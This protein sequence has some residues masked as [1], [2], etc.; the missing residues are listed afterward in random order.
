MSKQAIKTDA[1]PV[2]TGQ[3]DGVPT[4]RHP[5]FISGSVRIKHPIIELRLIGFFVALRNDKGPSRTSASNLHSY[6]SHQC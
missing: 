1:D 5:E 3:H 6:P 4:Y 2:H